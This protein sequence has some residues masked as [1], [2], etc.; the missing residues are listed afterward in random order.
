MSDSSPAPLTGPDLAA[1][2]IALADLAEGVLLRGH[3]HG[4]PVLL[5][6]RGNELL[7]VGARCSHFGAPLEQGLLV[8]DTVR[9]PWHHAC[10]SLRTGEA[11][12]APALNPLPSWTVMCRAG[13]A[14]VTGKPE[15]DPLA[16]APPA[17]KATE[18]SH[19]KTIVIVGAGGAGS[20]AAEML[21]REG[22]QG[23]LTLL[24]GEAEVPYDRTMLSKDFSAKGDHHMVLRPAGFYA[25]HDIELVRG[26][27]MTLGLNDRQVR[28][29]DGSAYPYEGL[30]LATGAE[31][32]L[33]SMKQPVP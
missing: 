11:M 10:F 29:A 20:T 21:R 2:G 33:R 12:R 32:V 27:V 9:C 1:E 6:R 3:A 22:Y 23:R 16:P 26:E 19:P 4:E 30:L 13:R 8:D 15:R 17:K 18:P 25:E 28:L 31:P 7:A 5:V 14:Y 24:D